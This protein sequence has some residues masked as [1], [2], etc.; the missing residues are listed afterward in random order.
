[1][2]RK[3]LAFAT[4]WL[5]ALTFALAATAPCAA[6]S[7]PGE[8]LQNPGFE[9]SLETHPWMPSA[10]DTS[11]TALP[12]VFFGRDTLLAHGGRRGIVRPHGIEHG[13]RDGHVR[14]PHAVLSSQD[15]PLFPHR[16]GQVGTPH[17]DTT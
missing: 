11:L 10:W 4:L 17:C 7:L 16:V 8:L 9:D 6:A 3:P 2:S 12:T 5:A 15:R 1:M 13:V 14:T